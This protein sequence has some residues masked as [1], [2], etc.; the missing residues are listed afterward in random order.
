MEKEREISVT[1]ALRVMFKSRKKLSDLKGSAGPVSTAQEPLTKIEVFIE[2]LGKEVRR[3]L[4]G[5]TLFFLFVLLEPIKEFLRD[6]W[7]RAI[8]VIENLLGRN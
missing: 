5:K 3:S 7:V 1:F 4:K 2:E 6:L 8:A